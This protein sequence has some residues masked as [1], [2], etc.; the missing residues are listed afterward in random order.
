MKDE[1]EK[2]NESFDTTDDVQKNPNTQ[3]G[4]LDKVDDSEEKDLS[5]DESK[6]LDAQAEELTEMSDLDREL[7]AAEGIEQMRTAEQKAEIINKIRSPEPEG[8]GKKFILVV[9]ILALLLLTAIG[10]AGFFYMQQSSA[11]SKANAL[12]AELD[13]SSQELASLKAKQ[14]AEAEKLAADEA[15]TAETSKVKYVTISELG[16]R[17]KVT[18]AN[19]ALVYGYATKSADTNIDSV[20]FSTTEL[21]RVVKKEGSVDTYPCGLVGGIAS[22][23]ITRY[24]KD[25]MVNGVMASKVGKKIGDAYYVYA[26]PQ[27]LCSD[28]LRDA[29]TARNTAVKAVFDSLEVIPANS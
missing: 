4:E 12:Q 16:V 3:S 15:K 25:V 18:D 21:A 13:T 7:R 23:E 2:Q 17:Y 22:P 1:S 24:K 10:V 9:A 29:Q 8:S 14:K 6:E 11:T 26:Q 28:T 27:S 20:A 19:K 5:V